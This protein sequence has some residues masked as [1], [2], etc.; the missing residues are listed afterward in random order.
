MEMRNCGIE[1]PLPS[2]N[3]LFIYNISQNVWNENH[4]VIG[5][6]QETLSSPGTSES[7]CGVEHPLSEI[8]LRID[9][10]LP[11]YEAVINRS[12]QIPV[13]S[14]RIPEILEVECTQSQHRN[15]CS[16]GRKYIIWIIVV[17]SAVAVTVILFS[18]F[19]SKM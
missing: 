5:Q 6:R 9:D 10:M 1:H 19:I 15:K 11:S 4:N 7:N 12:F 2:Y 14:A 16:R 8:V 17:I 18:I 13:T 3:E